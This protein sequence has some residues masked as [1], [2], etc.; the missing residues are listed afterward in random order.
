MLHDLILYSS[1]VQDE[2]NG[3]VRLSEMEMTRSQLSSRT[4]CTSNDATRTTCKYKRYT[5]IKKKKRRNSNTTKTK[6]IS[7]LYS[8][9]VSFFPH[10]SLY[11]PC[12]KQ[13]KNPFFFSTLK[14]FHQK[15]MDHDHDHMD[16][17]SP[18]MALMKKHYTSMTFF[19]STKAEVLFSDWPGNRG[20]MYALALIVVFLLA[21]VTEMVGSH[22][23]DRYTNG[24]SLMQTAVHLFRVGLMYILMLAVMS[25]NGGIFIAACIG[26]AAGFVLFRSAFFSKKPQD[27]ASCP[28]GTKYRDLPPMSC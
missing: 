10:F 27:E 11:K 15:K 2:W 1:P 26:H 24:R 4:V 17:M 6:F 22:H 12:K 14:N 3:D 23:V 7:P 21:A 5:N 8:L 19:W 28:N 16:P 9:F 13:R 25:F 20:G 18:P